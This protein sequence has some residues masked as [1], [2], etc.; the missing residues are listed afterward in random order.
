M[1]I[2]LDS[3]SD[4]VL[5]NII[6]E[7]V[8]REGTEYGSEDALLVDKIAQVKQQLVQ[9]KAMVVYSELY[10]TVNIVPKEEIS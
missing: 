2:P 10:Q 9:K 1:I 5:D 7:F 3:L 6:E 8:L 4:D